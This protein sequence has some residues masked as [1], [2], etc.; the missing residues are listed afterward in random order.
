MTEPTDDK[1]G[2]GDE[3]SNLVNLE[4]RRKA[5]RQAF[6]NAQPREKKPAA[7]KKAGKVEKT[8]VAGGGDGGAGDDEPPMERLPANCPVK[9]LGFNMNHYYFLSKAG[10]L[11]ELVAEKIGHLNILSLFGGDKWL[12]KNF[13]AK[14]KKGRIKKH[15]WNHG[16]VAPLLIA[17]CQHA[18]TWSPADKERGVGCWQEDD[19]TLVF[20]CGHKLF[21]SDGFVVDPGLRG[22]DQLVYPAAPALPEPINEVQA[23]DGAQY[24]TEIWGAREWGLVPGPGAA[25][26]QRL[27]TWEYARPLLDPM[28]ILGT[29]GCALLGAAP[30]W[31]PMMFITG[32][33]RTGKSTLL[34]GIKGLIGPDAFV[35]SGNATLAALRGL[36]GKSTKPVILDEF[37]RGDGAD[38]RR[39]EEV[40][41]LFVL[42][43]S[44][45]TL[46]RGSPGTETHRYQARSCCIGSAINLPGMKQQLIN[47]SFIIRL[48]ALNLARD[49]N[50]EKIVETSEMRVHK[51]WGAPALL[52][53]IGRELRGRLLAEWPRYRQTLIAYQ[54]AIRDIGHDRRT[55]DQFGA[56]LAAY[57]L[58]MFSSLDADRPKRYVTWLADAGI[59]ELS[60]QKEQHVQCLDY[61][62]G[63]TITMFRGGRLTTTGAMLQKM[64]RSP[65]TGEKYDEYDECLQQNGIKLIG[66]DN[67]RHP[68]WRVAFGTDH[69]GLARLFEGTQW[70]KKAGASAG[71]GSALARL[72]GAEEFYAGTHRR[73]RMRMEGRLNY[74]VT[75]PYETIFGGAGEKD[76][77]GDADASGDND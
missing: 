34:D 28:L 45:E 23:S 7:A 53:R 1:G 16:R 77:S 67:D 63:Q 32:P 42:S 37:E 4:Q 5:V 26:M 58:L 65:V 51:V 9:C 68:F 11:I 72:E 12:I 30:E 76:D 64:F 74:V 39:C 69:P 20:H 33:S 27:V 62:M 55:A 15:E 50:D 19:G 41:E 49:E 38:A 25:V 13:P 22:K 60:D 31:R 8:E 6:E 10:Q 52:V 46:D 40:L 47:R 3:Q 44:G 56:A 48:S 14:D 2:D 61:L 57:D 24:A 29:I 75:L 35:S 70:H 36:I 18:G 66:P 54:N 21:T 43:S 17:E 71:Y 73:L 59:T